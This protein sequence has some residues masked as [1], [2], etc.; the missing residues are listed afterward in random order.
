MPHIT[1]EIY[2]LYF[3]DREKKKSIHV[4]LWPLFAPKL[5]D[6]KAELAGDLGVDIIN[7]VRK[8]KSEQQLSMKEGFTRLVLG[9]ED[10]EFREMIKSMEA[11]LKAVLNVKE[12]VLASS[13]EVYQTAEK[14]PTDENE[15]LKIPDPLNPR[16]SHLKNFSREK[17][18]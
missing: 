5:V 2:H 3:A 18:V 1:E 14:I 16:Y 13:S 15:P 10:L 6:E 4:S 7:A 8:Y 12:I 9:N 11:D 17:L